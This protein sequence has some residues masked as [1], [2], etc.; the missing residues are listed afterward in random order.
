MRARADTRRKDQRNTNHERHGNYRKLELANDDDCLV[1][2]TSIIYKNASSLPRSGAAGRLILRQ[3]ARARRQQ[4]HHNN[5]TTTTTSVGTNNRMSRP[6]FCNTEDRY[7]LTAADGAGLRGR[8]AVQR[9]G[10]AVL[11]GLALSGRSAVVAGRHAQLGERAADGASWR[12]RG[13]KGRANGAGK[14]E[15]V[16]IRVALAD[17]RT[18]VM[19]MPRPARHRQQWVGWETADSQS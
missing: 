12:W 9:V 7:T 18:G 4:Q 2:R 15:R 6:P 8:E 17:R 5:S 19:A 16:S 10:A 14:G 1:G 3:N 11:R 13:G